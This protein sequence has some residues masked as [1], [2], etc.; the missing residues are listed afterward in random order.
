MQQRPVNNISLQVMLIYPIC[1]AFDSN[2]E[3]IVVRVNWYFYGMIISNSTV[4]GLETADRKT[5][6]S[7][8]SLQNLRA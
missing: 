5:T 4:Y 1:V 7:S 3:M 8:V 2:G 6:Y